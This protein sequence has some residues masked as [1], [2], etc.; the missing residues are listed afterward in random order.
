[1]NP[2][3]VISL[4]DAEVDRSRV[5]SVTGVCII[6]SDGR[7]FIFQFDNAYATSKFVFLCNE[8]KRIAQGDSLFM[9]QF[10]RYRPFGQSGAAIN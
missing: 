8:G 9:K 6:L 10:P 2:R 3:F 7:S 4:K 5:M 1:M